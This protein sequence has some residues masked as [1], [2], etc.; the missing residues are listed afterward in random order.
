MDEACGSQQIAEF[1]VTKYEQ[2]YNTVP[3]CANE[4]TEISDL[5]NNNI[6]EHSSVNIS[7]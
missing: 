6:C 5:I 1:F 4:L 3:T 2:L 7:Y